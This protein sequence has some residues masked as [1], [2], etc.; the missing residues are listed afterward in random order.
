MTGADSRPAWRD[1]EETFTDE[2][3]NM[4]TLGVMFADSARRN[5]ERPAQSYKGGIYDRS[6]TDSI[7]PS[8][9]EGEY[10]SITYERMNDVVRNLATG[11]RE[12]GIGADDRVGLF[13]STRM[14]W[15]LCDFAVLSAGGVVTT[16]YTESS[17]KQVKYL[18]D[19]PDAD[20]V[21]VE[22][23]TLLERVLE[24][25]DDLSLSVIV[26]M[27][28]VDV[29]RDDVYSLAAVHDIG[30]A[31]FDEATY[32]SWLDERDP[33]DLAS[34]IYTSGTTGQPKG[35]ELTHRNFRANVNQARK[36]LGPRADKHPDLPSVEAGIRTISF[37][38]L[39]HVFE[40]TAGHFFAFAS[41]GNVGYVEN[42][43][44]LADDIKQIQ[45][46]M[47][48]SVPRVYERIFDSMRSQASESALKTRIFEWAIDV[49]RDYAD[50]D[51]P[52]PILEFK[53]TV[54]DRLVYS[55]VKEQLGGELEFMVSGGGS[56][57]KNLCATFLGMGL[58]IIEG[59]GL[60]E[61]APILTINPPED[62]RPGTLGV[63]VVDVDVRIDTDVVD[64][65]Q[66]DDV[67][68]ELGELLVDGPNVASG[69][70]NQPGAT[71]RAFTEEDGVRW[72][73]TGDIVEQTPDDFLVYHDRIKEVI[74]LSTGKNV[75]PQPIEDKFATSD[76]VDQIMVVGD[77]QK[78]I[79]A[80]V[81]PNFERL[82]QWAEREGVD[83]PADD[84]E[85]CGDDRVRAWIREE[86]DDG[87]EDLEKVE[88]IKEFE[89]VPKEWTAENNL[90][91]PSMKKK[92]RN[93]RTEFESKLRA[94][95]GDDYNDG[96]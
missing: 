59:Y 96:D 64:E 77:D 40:R 10:A 33:D 27:D 56:L 48:A 89:L 58:T 31:A 13:A 83:L 85:R 71:K 34:L 52:G 25:E 8:A 72:F 30:E 6:L 75:A 5:A 95:Y 4:E 47:G 68:G 91:T 81:V 7:V 15:A 63:P 82:E 70:W 38:P 41:G 14:E 42:P 74:V 20:A 37:L 93:I 22:N 79:A 43:D 28:E 9:P 76:R 62:I 84:Y 35:V 3:I 87:N 12:L 45:P 78:F 11:F 1:A 46:N 61:T 69:Y 16:V 21:V 32:Q 86:I 39:A 54:A 44:T 50:N 29:D 57:S 53:H 51:D 65:S 19:D 36:R 73:R 67:T 88:R 60:T 49:A 26:V 66:F 90:L 17:A 2:T 94:I 92:R 18:L 80:L 55:T 24:V 23:E